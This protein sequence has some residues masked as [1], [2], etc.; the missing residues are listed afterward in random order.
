MSAAQAWFQRKE[1]TISAYLFLAPTILLVSV[2]TVFPVLFSLFLSFHK[3]DYISAARPFVGLD[4]FRRL[5]N[6][7]RFWSTLANSA[8]YGFA[9]M[10][11]NI[12]V[13][14][15]L[16]LMV[17]QKLR[18][19][20]IF[21]S[22]YF[23]PVVTSSVAVGLIWSWIFDPAFGPLNYA[24]S[25]VGI[26]PQ[27]WLG[28]PKLALYSLVVMAVWNGVG[29]NKMLFLA[30][31]QGIPQ[32]YYDAAVVDGA[33]TLQQFRMITIPLLSPTTFFV[34]ITGLIGA[35]QVFDQIYLL[36]KGGP[37]GTTRTIVF[38]LWEV[39]FESFEMGYAS[40]VA[41]FLFGVI[42]LLTLL[43]YRFGSRFV[44]YQ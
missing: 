11:L 39:G 15:I 14:M 42:F 1:E 3:W 22:A 23:S 35:L 36:T 7:P 37:A 17:N 24:L 26:G 4:N 31:L 9:I 41:Y 43:N 33:N 38:Y 5:I 29:Y 21:R 13:A 10:P 12:A 20:T 25:L 19:I 8:R 30:G 6:T 40:A 34:F 28:S 44:H 32:E 27:M 16:A 2:F 18:G